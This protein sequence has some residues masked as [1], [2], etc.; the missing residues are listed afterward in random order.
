MLIYIYIFIFVKDFLI[1]SYIFKPVMHLKVVNSTNINDLQYL[2]PSNSKT[3]KFPKRLKTKTHSS[4]VFVCTIP[5]WQMRLSEAG[6]G[7]LTWR[8]CLHLPDVAGDQ[9]S[10]LQLECTKAW[11][12][13][14]IFKIDWYEAGSTKHVNRLDVTIMICLIFFWYVDLVVPWKAKKK[15]QEFNIYMTVLLCSS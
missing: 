13:S 7:Y 9:R 5:L 11:I 14:A 6:N 15:K 12:A 10:S 1:F 2:N 8:D 3:D 4:S